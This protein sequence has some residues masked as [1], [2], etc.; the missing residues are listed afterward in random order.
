[1]LYAQ[2]PHCNLTRNWGLSQIPL[3]DI[4]AKLQQRCYGLGGVDKKGQIIL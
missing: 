1:M 2:R 4:P 3:K